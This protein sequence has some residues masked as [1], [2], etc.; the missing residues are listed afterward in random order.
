L[1]D[2][3]SVCKRPVW[4]GGHGLNERECDQTLGEV[5]RLHARIIK[6][7]GAWRSLMAVA[8][9]LG[10]TTIHPEVVIARAEKALGGIA[11]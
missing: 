7:E 4:D 3:C 9:E 2:T 1:T 6:L 5:C 10:N 8:K 11:L